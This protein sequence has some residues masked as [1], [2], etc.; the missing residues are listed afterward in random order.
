M[1]PPLQVVV[2]VLH[3]FVELSPLT[4]RTPVPVLFSTM[5]FVGPVPGVPAKMLRNSR[6]LELIVVFATFNAVPVV[7]VSVFTKAPV[8]P[9]AQG[10]SSHT[11]TVPP[12]VAVNAGLAPVVAETPPRKLI[13]APVLLV[14]DT[15]CPVSVT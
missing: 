11:S 8:P 3:V 9:G 6:L 2:P 14:S 10:F 13:A 1:V 4:R 15:P 12:P 5:P 7:V